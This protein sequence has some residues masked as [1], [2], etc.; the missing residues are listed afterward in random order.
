MD[1]VPEKVWGIVID[2]IPIIFVI[3]ATFSLFM[4]LSGQYSVG[5]PEKVGRYGEGEGKGEAGGT[6]CQIVQTMV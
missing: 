1:G 6:H 5:S 2:A 4:R 3:D